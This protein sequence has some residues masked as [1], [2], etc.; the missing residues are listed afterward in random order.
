MLPVDGRRQSRPRYNP[1]ALCC[2]AATN[3]RK[4]ERIFEMQEEIATSVAGSLGV[5][6]GVGDVNAF[7]GAGTR[8]IEAYEAYLQA[9]SK[10][11]ASSG[12][13]DA[14]PLLERAINL[15]PYDR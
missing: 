10:D 5:R 13:S 1:V 7:H 9:Q 12:V 4:L 15:D 14:I 8:N 6:L 11:W 2:A 3:N